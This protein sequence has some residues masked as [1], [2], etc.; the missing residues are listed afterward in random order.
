M[1]TTSI[2]DVGGVGTPLTD[3]TA[4]VVFNS[5]IPWINVLGGTSGPSGSTDFNSVIPYNFSSVANDS[6]TLGLTGLAPNAISR[7]TASANGGITNPA[8]V[9]GLKTTARANFPILVYDDPTKMA[10]PPTHLNPVMPTSVNKV[11]WNDRWY[12]VGQGPT[13]CITSSDGMKWSGSSL[14]NPHLTSIVDIAFD[15]NDLGVAIGVGATYSAS[16]L[17]GGEVWFPI[18][19]GL[20]GVNN[21]KAVIKTSKWIIIG[22]GIS[23]SYN[24]VIWN[25]VVPATDNISLTSIAWDQLSNVHLAVGTNSTGGPLLYKRDSNG[26]WSNI[27]SSLNNIRGLYTR[28]EI[29]HTLAVANN[30]NG[31]NP[32][33]IVA[34]RTDDSYDVRTI[35]SDLS[36]SW[37]PSE[38][39][40]TD[41][42]I[43]RLY[44]D[45]TRWVAIENN[46]FAVSNFSMGGWTRTQLPVN[47]SLSSYST[48]TLSPPV[49]RPIT[50]DTD[51]FIRDPSLSGLSATTISDIEV[52]PNI[53]VKLT[54][55]NRTIRGVVTPT[56]TFTIEG[57]LPI[58]QSYSSPSSYRSFSLSFRA[59]PYITKY[60][61]FATPDGQSF[62]MNLY[63]NKLSAP[64]TFSTNTGQSSAYSNDGMVYARLL[65]TQTI[66]TVQTSAIAK[67]AAYVSALAIPVSSPPDVFPSWY[68]K[69]STNFYQ[70]GRMQFYAPTF[71]VT[72]SSWNYDLTQFVNLT[73]F[74]RVNYSLFSS[75]GLE[76]IDLKSMVD[77]ISYYG[78][79]NFAQFEAMYEAE[80]ERSQ[81][82]FDNF[83]LTSMKKLN[84]HN[85]QPYNKGQYPY[86]FVRYRYDAQGGIIPNS[87]LLATGY[88]PTTVDGQLRLKMT[89]EGKGIAGITAGSYRDY[90]ENAEQFFAS[91]N[92]KFNKGVIYTSG[93]T[94]AGL[95]VTLGPGLT[96]YNVTAPV[97]KDTSAQNGVLQ[98]TINSIATLESYITTQHGMLTSLQSNINAKFSSL[99]TTIA[100]LLSNINTRAALLQAQLNLSSPQ[101]TIPRY[102]ETTVFNVKY[103]G[104]NLSFYIDDVLFKQYSVLNIQPLSVSMNFGNITNNT[105]GLAG[106]DW[107]AK[108]MNAL[109]LSN[110]G[111]NVYGLTCSFRQITLKSLGTEQIVSAID[112]EYKIQYEKIDNRDYTSAR[113]IEAVT[114]PIISGTMPALTPLQQPFIP[115]DYYYTI[116]RFTTDINLLLICATLIK[117]DTV[118]TVYSPEYNAARLAY[119]NVLTNQVN[120]TRT[121]LSTLINSE[122]D[123]FSNSNYPI[124][125]DHDT[126]N[127]SATDLLRQ[128]TD[129]PIAYS[130]SDDYTF[131]LLCL[132]NIAQLQAY[133]DS[134]VTY[135]SLLV[136]PYTAQGVTGINFRYVEPGDTGSTGNTLQARYP[137]IPDRTAIKAL[138]TK[139]NY[140]DWQYN[141]GITGGVIPEYSSSGTTGVTGSP[142]IINTV[143]S[144][145]FNSYFSNASASASGVSG[146]IQDWTNLLQ[147]IISDVLNEPLNAYSVAATYADQM[148]TVGLNRVADLIIKQKTC[149]LS[150]ARNYLN[151]MYE[152]T[153]VMFAKTTK[154]QEKLIWDYYY[155][156]ANATIEVNGENLGRNVIIRYQRSS[157]SLT[158]YPQQTITFDVE[159]ITGSFRVYRIGEN[160]SDYSIP[161]QGYATGII[162]AI[163]Y[164]PTST[165]RTT[166]L[167]VFYPETGN[168]TETAEFPQIFTSSA[169]ARTTLE[170]LIG[171]TYAI[172]TAFGNAVSGTVRSGTI[173]E[174]NVGIFAQG[175]MT[176]NY[177]IVLDVTV[178]LAA[179][180]LD[181]TD[182][183]FQQKGSY[184]DFSVGSAYNGGLITSIT[185]EDNVK[186]AV[187]PIDFYSY[188]S[189]SSI[190]S[191]SSG[192]TYGNINYSTEYPSVQLGPTGATGA[193]LPNTFPEIIHTFGTDSSEL[194]P[195]AT[196][197]S[198]LEPNFT[199]Q[200]NTYFNQNFGTSAIPASVTSLYDKYVPL[201]MFKDA[202]RFTNAFVYRMMEIKLY[203]GDCVM[204]DPFYTT[205]LNEYLDAYNQYTNLTI[206][207]TTI[208]SIIYGIRTQIN[209]M[210]TQYF[211]SSA[212]KQNANY[213][214]S[215]QDNALYSEYFPAFVTSAFNSNYSGIVTTQRAQIATFV[216][217]LP[218]S[219][220]DI[221]Q[222]TTII[223]DF[224]AAML[225]YTNEINVLTASANHYILNGFKS[226]F[227]TFY[228]SQRLCTNV[229]DSKQ[230]FDTILAT[231][232]AAEPPEV[233]SC[234]GVVRN[235]IVNIPPND[236][237]RWTEVTGITGTQYNYNR[238]NTEWRYYVGDTVAYKDKVYRCIN[239]DRSNTI[240]GVAPEPFDSL[241]VWATYYSPP[242][243]TVIPE[244][245]TSSTPE[246]SYRPPYRLNLTPEVISHFFKEGIAP[247]YYD[248]YTSWAVLGP[249]N[250]S[251]YTGVTGT[252]GAIPGG[253]GVW[254]LDSDFN[255]ENVPFYGEEFGYYQ[256]MNAKNARNP[257]LLIPP[258]SVEGIYE[259]GDLVSYNGSVYTRLAN[260]STVGIDP[261]IPATATNDS[262]W[263]ACPYIDINSVGSSLP[264]FSR[265][266][267]YGYGT[268]V[269]FGG[270]VYKY[271][272]AT[273]YV[274]YN[275]T[276][277]YA[278]GAVVLYNDY[279][280]EAK[281]GGLLPTPPIP[282]D[283]AASD[284]W[285]EMGPYGS[286]PDIRI[287]SPD[288]RYT[289]GEFLLNNSILFKL[290]VSV[291]ITQCRI[292]L[293]ALTTIPFEAGSPYVVSFLTPVYANTITVTPDNQSYIATINLPVGRRSP[294]P[295]G[296]VNGWTDYSN[297]IY[298]I[299]VNPALANYQTAPPS[300]YVATA[301]LVTAIT[302]S[303]TLPV[304]G[305]NYTM[306]APSGVVPAIT[307]PVSGTDQSNLWTVIAQYNPGVY[308]SEV[309][310]YDPKVNY[311]IL[312]NKVAPIDLP[313]SHQIAFNNIA[314]AVTARVEAESMRNGLS[315]QEGLQAAAIA[316]NEEKVSYIINNSLGPV[317]HLVNYDGAIWIYKKIINFENFPK[318][319]PDPFQ[320]WS[321]YPAQNPPAAAYSPTTVYIPGDIVLYKN[322]TFICISA[323]FGSATNEYD[324]QVAVSE[325][326]QDSTAHAGT[327]TESQTGPVLDT[328]VI[329]GNE[330]SSAPKWG[331][332]IVFDHWSVPGFARDLRLGHAN[333]LELAYVT[334]KHDL[335]VFFTSEPAITSAFS[336]MVTAGITGFDHT[337]TVNGV[338]GTLGFTNYNSALTTI[339]S[340]YSPI[341]F[342]Y[343]SKLIKSVV[344]FL[345]VIS[346]LNDKINAVK[347][348]WFNHK[349]TSIREYWRSNL[350]INPPNPT[351]DGNTQSTQDL[352]IS[353]ILIEGEVTLTTD[354][355]RNYQILLDHIVDFPLAV[356]V[357]NDYRANSGGQMRDSVGANSN[358]DTDLFWEGKGSSSDG[359]F[360]ALFN[361][362]RPKDPLVPYI[363]LGEDTAPKIL[364]IGAGKTFF[365]SCDRYYQDYLFQV[366]ML[367]E[368]ME[369]LITALYSM[370][371]YI[372]ASKL[373]NGII[374]NNPE[375]VHKIGL[376]LK[377]GTD[378]DILVPILTLADRYCMNLSNTDGW[379]G[380]TNTPWVSRVDGSFASPTLGNQGT[381]P[382][383]TTSTPQHTISSLNPSGATGSNPFNPDVSRLTEPTLQGSC[384]II[385]QYSDVV[386]AFSTLV[387]A[388]LSDF[389]TNLTIGNIY[390][391]SI[392]V[393]GA[394]ITRDNVRWPTVTPTEL[395]KYQ[396]KIPI[397]SPT[398]QNT[399]YFYRS[400]LPYVQLAQTFSMQPPEYCYTRSDTARRV[401][402]YIEQKYRQ[403]R[404][405]QKT[406]II[407]A[408]CVVVVGAILT[409]GSGG[410]ASAVIGPSMAIAMGT[411][412]GALT[413][414]TTVSGVLSLAWP[415]IEGFQVFNNPYALMTGSDKSAAGLAK[416][417]QALQSLVYAASGAATVNEQVDDLL[418]AAPALA[419]YTRITYRGYKWMQVY[420]NWLKT[421]QVPRVKEGYVPASAEPGLNSLFESI[422]GFVSGL[423]GGGATGGTLITYD[424]AV[425]DD[426]PGNYALLCVLQ[427]IQ[428]AE[429]FIAMYESEVKIPPIIR[430]V[431]TP[432]PAILRV[433]YFK[434]PATPYTD[435][436]TGQVNTSPGYGGTVTALEVVDP[437]EGFFAVGGDSTGVGHVRRFQAFAS[438]GSIASPSQNIIVSFAVQY[439]SESSIR[440]IAQVKVVDA[441]LA[442]P[443]IAIDTAGRRLFAE[444][445]ISPGNIDGTMAGGSQLPPL[446]SAN[447][448]MLSILNHSKVD[449]DTSIKWTLEYQRDALID[450]SASFRMQSLRESERQRYIT[451]I[452]NATGVN[453]SQ[454]VSPSIQDQTAAIIK[455]GNELAT[456]Y[457]SV[458]SEAATT[459]GTAAR[460]AARRAAFLTRPTIPITEIPTAE[461]SA[462]W[463]SAYAS[464]N[465]AAVEAEAG[466]AAFAVKYSITQAIAFSVIVSER[467]RSSAASSM[468]DL[469]QWAYPPIDPETQ[470]NSF[471]GT[472]FD[473]AT[474]VLVENQN[475]IVT[476]SYNA[477]LVAYKVSQ[478]PAYI[479]SARDTIKGLR[480]SIVAAANTFSKTLAQVRIARG[481]PLLGRAQRVINVANLR[482]VAAVRG[483]TVSNA[484]L[485]R[486]VTPPSIQALAQKPLF[487]LTDAGYDGIIAREAA[488]NAANPKAAAN[489]RMFGT[490]N[491]DDVISTS[492][493]VVDCKCVAPPN[494]KPPAPVS[495]AE[496]SR[497]SARANPKIAAV[498]NNW[499]RNA[500]YGGAKT[501]VQTKPPPVAPPTKAAS[502]VAAKAA[503]TPAAANTAKAA[504]SSARVAAADSVRAAGITNRAVANAATANPA[505]GGLVSSRVNSITR[506]G[507]LASNSVPMPRNHVSSN[508]AAFRGGP[509]DPN[510]SKYRGAGFQPEVANGTPEGPS[511]KI[512]AIRNNV[513]PPVLK[514]PPPII[515][516]VIE[517]IRTPGPWG[518]G[519]KPLPPMQPMLVAPPPILSPTPPPGPTPGGPCKIES[520]PPAKSQ[521]VI[522]R[523]VGFRTVPT[524]KPPI[525]A[526][527]GAALKK[528]GALLGGFMQ[529]AML[530]Y[531]IYQATQLPALPNDCAAL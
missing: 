166:S 213:Y 362:E 247:E 268:Y 515:R 431:P 65:R 165:G 496:A 113:S 129:Y 270:T 319:E 339:T 310:D 519:P 127:A 435:P 205:A 501:V 184:V 126:F 390:P 73:Q 473:R 201:T 328:L 398:N 351:A 210:L 273:P 466:R 522:T 63:N 262:A 392:G 189:P 233:D 58:P 275:S 283:R 414:A 24:G 492:Q 195:R 190:F 5:E 51:V 176:K 278:L 395:W 114:I 292:L 83:P 261:T 439:I 16:F 527:V 372:S 70:E 85:L 504:T 253:Q 503:S 354:V 357:Q 529:R 181:S 518:P 370:T 335:N 41:L 265:S 32:S 212:L 353:P 322:F 349:F 35:P 468:E 444:Y 7:N 464:K 332:G 500:E 520:L 163:A 423:T 37:L 508:T 333:G 330:T 2:N 112:S 415:E 148:N 260:S 21:L 92:D 130:A 98:S 493:T 179:L 164:T 474:T 17:M 459:A 228:N 326:M 511:S 121:N 287:F 300:P 234:D 269:K 481:Y 318:P 34:C 433:K 146:S 97:F 483:I 47:A 172:K 199:E 517:P 31:A 226:S 409:A 89:I 293:P 119:F 303:I 40:T 356:R 441:R 286:N 460:T 217:S 145:N 157:G 55:I 305:G 497:A 510:L 487:D 100:T 472:V 368:K 380:T 374:S 312:A 139:L 224:Q 521:R 1:A 298:E 397:S 197:M 294:S 530:A 428:N 49:S 232:S 45:G 475:E 123:A 393:T 26:V 488:F 279:L 39:M 125:I 13:N 18:V 15:D 440:G 383:V 204:G 188:V 143:T 149:D 482:G 454:I 101:T 364:A 413:L 258:Y 263:L 72:D 284:T 438:P 208:D 486:Q 57:N 450:A 327:I 307:V 186:K 171:K 162:Q 448:R 159:E 207:Q 512:K 373:M 399:T 523:A 94:G 46:S 365:S 67:L 19:N 124:Y 329:P 311:G 249:A 141:I 377:T 150:F 456:R 104:V 369:G 280:Y 122:N 238:F 11:T 88:F 14:N 317:V 323:S 257:Y 95:P 48:K 77:S 254:L 66:N 33:W 27:T 525:G 485:A 476:D 239:T 252:T 109:T 299:I 416:R 68:D 342:Y 455:A 187:V 42:R 219:Y 344:V 79:L 524:V 385:H 345:D 25:T 387:S 214:F 168:T 513:K 442:G 167:T 484:Q 346:D 417:C 3:T 430:P 134:A 308:F 445:R 223:S 382:G 36:G 478:L 203:G 301:P 131:V 250:K 227:Y 241:I 451:A 194:L 531:Q 161:D 272:G 297:P 358:P 9:I 502:A 461:S 237:A 341:E 144:S 215:P 28:P 206:P 230:R 446:Y 306:R 425:M 449:T 290:N 479:R 71:A 255:Q 295:Y 309:T 132:L 117:Q 437:G 514:P 106:S 185:I 336:R 248:I 78:D 324:Q 359:R 111:V 160:Y 236:T 242:L 44:S 60:V 467:A 404:E 76:S 396:G 347:T 418:N 499:V 267:A 410:T 105:Q 81:W 90:T 480:S 6:L 259:I 74:Q 43:T 211:N 337:L 59:D 93:I 103:D 296:Q 302:S 432:R 471:Q 391:G 140:L 154:E 384:P 498:E 379:M 367:N 196:Y 38:E 173:R 375:E 491:I 490:S 96:G 363:P 366:E 218:S 316:V 321:V 421:V 75:M 244:A 29:T 288:V 4:R 276:T 142:G 243:L 470:S 277:N 352:E 389:K 235:F 91:A 315:Y 225:P 419:N 137:V 381:I 405:N 320:A 56:E 182:T 388:N 128:L 402:D 192:I 304:S 401:N 251:L 108:A 291:D 371:G 193:Y 378:D 424:P 220:T 178:A 343:Y 221:S 340:A 465:L 222:V 403:Q 8:N 463:G 153:Q 256:A 147:T 325:F 245:A 180:V 110:A 400:I 229:L 331:N 116:S 266:S 420:L 505:R 264:E 407:T 61:T 240:S 82:K 458:L 135:R 246:A 427:E 361:I 69:S 152:A 202:T 507:N 30:N 271:V 183:V 360:R 408:V 447:E 133:Y 169:Q 376:S 281:V 20:T 200:F 462:N 118:T 107:N 10:Y 136:N 198:Y 452:S 313:L 443:T 457:G 156:L 52:I 84:E 170:T 216:S 495:A 394:Y 64:V 453:P 22:D 54:P 177:S 412:G 509:V 506:S 231:V 386:S 80:A 62:S 86:T 426:Q 338:T 12:A 23:E 406:A 526:V 115:V 102:S 334:Y 469:Y 191:T 355:N 429:I 174:I 516:P 528:G 289:A 155:G 151:V 285:Y 175:V 489:A 422:P 436:V 53:E 348:N 274:S 282:V 120:A 99:N 494:T 87:A 350:Q 434:S 314:N 50:T 158:P 138:S 411:L 209:P 477:M